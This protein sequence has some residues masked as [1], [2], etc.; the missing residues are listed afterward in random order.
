[1]V[2][3]KIIFTYIKKNFPNLLNLIKASFKNYFIS[4]YNFY[5]LS[6]VWS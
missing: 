1:M 5:V 6:Y 4:Q 2:S 3:L